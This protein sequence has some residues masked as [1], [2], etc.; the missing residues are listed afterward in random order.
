MK[1]HIFRRPD[2][3][4]G[5]DTSRDFAARQG[6]IP[7]ELTIDDEASAQKAL[8]NTHP[9]AHDRIIGIVERYVAERGWEAERRA[10]N[11][12]V[13]RERAKLIPLTLWQK[14]KRFFH[15]K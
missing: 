6:D 8:K 1:I 5:A 11:L 10:P 4:A 13:E 3:S 7:H 15:A 12:Q 9:L 2:G 14:I